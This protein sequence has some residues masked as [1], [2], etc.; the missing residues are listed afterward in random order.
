MIT[1][2]IGTNVTRRYEIIKVAYFF[3]KGNL[4]TVVIELS[5]KEVKRLQELF[6]ILVRDE[7]DV[8]DAIHIIIENA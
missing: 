3:W 8:Q 5:E 7:E 4:M 2:K 6:G 1:A